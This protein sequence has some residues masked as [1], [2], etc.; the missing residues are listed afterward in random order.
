MCIRDR[1]T[2]EYVSEV[3]EVPVDKIEEGVRIYTTRLNPLHGNGGIHYQL[4]PDQ[5]GHAVQNTRALQLIACI[6]GNSDEPAGNRGSSKAQVDG[7]CGRA[8]MLVTDHEPKDW[9][10]DVGTMELGN[11]PRDLSVEDQIPLIQN[12]VQY[13]IDEKSPLAERY[14]NKVPTAEEARWIAERKGGAYKPVS[15]THLTLPT[16]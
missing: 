13:L 9:G 6:T 4:A 1:Y 12:F 16:T 8:N 5:T 15:Y 14:G 3:T 11:T 10:L 2:L 7:C